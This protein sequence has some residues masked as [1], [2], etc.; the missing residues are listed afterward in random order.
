MATMY[1]ILQGLPLFKGTSYEQIS[2]FLEKTNVEFVK[3]VPGDIICKAGEPCK[4]IKYVLGGCVCVRM[5][6]NG[7]RAVLE[8]TLGEGNVFTPAHLFGLDTVYP[9]SVISESE[10]KL[11]LITKSQYFDTLA[12]D[13]LFVLNYINYLGYYAQ[14]KLHVIRN[15]EG[16]S[17]K[18]WIGALVSGIVDRHALSASIKTSIEA[19][20]AII[21]VGQECIE[22]QLKT[23]C[24]QGLLTYSSDLDTIH[25]TLKNIR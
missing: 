4:H 10:G 14:K 24:E 1:E 23:L 7:G 17:L 12:K 8:Q 20:S 25:I 19:L 9:A 5:E 11:M 3:H 15:M 13:P 2:A 16:G 21:G 18:A 22:K 6:L